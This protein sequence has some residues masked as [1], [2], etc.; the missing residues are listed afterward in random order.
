[1]KQFL[2]DREVAERYSVS[3]PTVWRWVSEGHLPKP[4]KVGPGSTR[5]RIAD[6]DAH[7]A[8]FGEAA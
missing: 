8:K 5:W 6:L 4:V 7:D 2:N 1:M 3:R